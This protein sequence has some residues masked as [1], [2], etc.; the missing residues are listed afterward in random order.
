MVGEQRMGEGNP[1][2]DGR[3]DDKGVKGDHL[4]EAHQHQAGKEIPRGSTEVARNSLTNFQ[5]GDD[6]PTLLITH[7][8]NGGGFDLTFIARAQEFQ[9]QGD[10]HIAQVHNAT[11]AGH[12]EHLVAARKHLE[13]SDHVARAIQARIP[14]IVAALE[15]ERNKAQA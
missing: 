11:A 4:L 13:A 7:I 3:I 12:S 8:T 14:H 15:T 10:H 5:I 1:T 9:R 2:G 6:N